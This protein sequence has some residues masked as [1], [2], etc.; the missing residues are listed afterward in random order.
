MTKL[1][2]IKVPGDGLL[3]WDKEALDKAVAELNVLIDRHKGDNK[4]PLRDVIKI[5]GDGQYVVA[6]VSTDHSTD[7]DLET[8]IKEVAPGSVVKHAEARR[9]Q[10]KENHF[11]GSIKLTLGDADITR[12][13][14]FTSKL[15]VF[16]NEQKDIVLLRGQLFPP[17]T[18]FTI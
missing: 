13:D 6:H 14:L 5:M 12:H 17:G 9:E 11:R 7:P 3:G 2:N 15:C 18:R 10:D 4:I 8:V 16:I 1:E